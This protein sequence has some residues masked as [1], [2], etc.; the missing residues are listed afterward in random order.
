[1][2][3]CVCSLALRPKPNMA[4]PFPCCRARSAAVKVIGLTSEKLPTEVVPYR[5][6]TPEERSERARKAVAAREAKK[7]LN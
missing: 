1:M 2:L 3:N 6:M 7:T 5:D 4:L